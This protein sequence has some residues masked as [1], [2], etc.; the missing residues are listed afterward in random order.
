MNDN[1]PDRHEL[2]CCYDDCRGR[3]HHLLDD[4]QQLREA[5]AE[6]LTA[7]AFK[8][9]LDHGDLAPLRRAIRQYDSSAAT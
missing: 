1:G 9:R 5:A 6:V 2:Q 7:S 3:L 8:D 4:A